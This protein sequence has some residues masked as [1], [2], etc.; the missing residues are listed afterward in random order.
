MNIKVLSV[1]GLRP[2]FREVDRDLWLWFCEAKNNYENYHG[3]RVTKRLV[4]AKAKQAFEAVGISNFKAS[5]GWYIRWLKRWNRINDHTA[6]SPQVLK[7]QRIRRSNAKTPAIANKQ[8]DNFF[9]KPAPSVCGP[10]E[11][12]CSDNAFDTTNLNYVGISQPGESESFQSL[13]SDEYAHSFVAGGKS[14]P[15][16]LIFHQ[17]AKINPT[18]AVLLPEQCAQSASQ[19][20]KPV[21][22]DE[23]SSFLNLDDLTWNDLSDLSCFGKPSETIFTENDD[24]KSLPV[25]HPKPN[26]QDNHISFQDREKLNRS[27][28]FIYNSQGPSQQNDQSFVKG[29]SLLPKRASKFG[30]SAEKTNHIHC[31]DSAGGALVIRGQES[32]SNDLK[33]KET[34]NI[35]CNQSMTDFINGETACGNFAQHDLEDVSLSSD[36]VN[37][38]NNEQTFELSIKC[39]NVN[40][41]H[42][43][44]SKNIANENANSH[45]WPDNHSKPPTSTGS[46]HTVTNSSRLK[47]IN[48]CTSPEPGCHMSVVD[49]DLSSEDN[50]YISEAVLLSMQEDD[51]SILNCDQSPFQGNMSV[52]DENSQ[53]ESEKVTS[54]D[55]GSQLELPIFKSSQYILMDK[56]HSFPCGGKVKKCGE[57]PLMEDP[58]AQSRRPEHQNIFASEDAVRGEILSSCSRDDN[59]TLEVPCFTPMLPFANESSNMLPIMDGSPVAQKELLTSSASGDVIFEGGKMFQISS[60]TGKIALV[61]SENLLHLSTTDSVHSSVS[62]QDVLIASCNNFNNIGSL[63]SSYFSTEEVVEYSQ[64]PLVSDS[65]ILNQNVESAYIVPCSQ[66]EAGFDNVSQCSASNVILSKNLSSGMLKSMQLNSIEVHGGSF[67][68]MLTANAD[69]RTDSTSYLLDGNGGVTRLMT[70]TPSGTSLGDSTSM[71]ASLT[72]TCTAEISTQDQRNCLINTSQSETLACP[73]RYESTKENGFLSFDLPLEENMLSETDADSGEHSKL[74]KKNLAYLT[75][76]GM[77]TSLGNNVVEAKQS[78][79]RRSSGDRYFPYFKEKV[80]NYAIKNT[81]K[82]AAQYFGVNVDTVT[83]WTRGRLENNSVVKNY[84]DQLMLRWLKRNRE[85]GIL[86]TKEQV[87]EK[88]INLLKTPGNWLKDKT[89]WFYTWASRFLGEEEKKKR[90][91]NKELGFNN[92]PEDTGDKKALYPDEFKVEVVLYAERTS[93]NLAS[94]IFNIARRRIFEWSAALKSSKKEDEETTAISFSNPK[95]SLPSH[96]PLSSIPESGSL[97]LKL[98]GKGTGR[99]VTSVAV[100]QELWLWFCEQTAK[101]TKPKSKEIRVKAVELF[102]ARNHDKIQCSH[103]WL[104][105]WC[106]RYGVALRHEGDGDLLAWCLEQFDC[107]RN[108]SHRDL[109]NYAHESLTGTHKSEFKA[110]AGWLLRFCKRHKNLLS[111]K[112]S[113]DT[114]IPTILKHKV[115]EFRAHVQK[116]I[117]T[118]NIC[119]ENVGCMDEI[120]LNFTAGASRNRLL[121]RRSGLENCHATVI[122]G[123]L[124][125]GELLPPAIIFKGDG[126]TEHVSYNGLPLIIFYQPDCCMNSS[127]M[128]QWIDLVWTRNVSSPSLVVADCYDPHCSE[129]VQDKCKASNIT[130]SVMPAGCSFKLQPLDPAISRL[131]EENIYNR[132]TRHYTAADQMLTCK[133]T[134]YSSNTDIARWVADACSTLRQTRKEAMQRSFE[135]TGLTSLLK[136][137][138]EQFIED[139]S[140]IPFASLFTSL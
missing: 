89:R 55:E 96:G 50:D 121:L 15:Q 66:D 123:C 9:N 105:K 34:E 5:D 33:S 45:F 109:L 70:W 98:N 57:T 103:G 87:V 95:D 133:R 113:I 6:G 104:K 72:N 122:L 73:M 93:Q 51:F 129:S 138:D 46:H 19:S 92:L 54:L 86:L 52:I 62:D 2:E 8:K 116:I 41:S 126:P 69:T 85:S 131:F 102:R 53:S 23:E 18:D 27:D 39:G 139:P 125:N 3:P 63:P 82:E 11:S 136:K 91:E 14:T 80:V 78:S 111:E 44:C 37:Q 81:A 43:I 74:H 97:K 137:T 30:S 38:L 42:L 114:E 61:D 13:D 60:L 140:Y 32:Q 112:P 56:E 127:I 118:S 22:I 79:Y 12:S 17:T 28:V 25:E 26:Q 83:L 128:S 4:Q 132:W 76:K 75:E 101:K 88:A 119:E 117:K 7:K 48:E 36:F 16:S 10:L 120:P 68:D 58:M 84:P 40:N 108:I 77:N 100:D 94:N 35:V 47:T 31:R 1:R 124:A 20:L 99:A 110:S 134:S 24:L 135:V 90:M 130:L 106:M 49:D 115:S 107:N 71:L 59:L 67:S 21:E 29:F 64:S 65:C